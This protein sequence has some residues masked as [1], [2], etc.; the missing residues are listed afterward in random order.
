MD[1]PINLEEKEQITV[2]DQDAKLLW[3]G[4]EK[5][6]CIYITNF[7][8]IIFYDINE[9]DSQR[10]L[11][12]ITK[13]VKYLPNYEVLLELEIK[14]IVEIVREEKFDKYLLK[15]SKYFYL[16]SESAYKVLLK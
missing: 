7:R 16:L 10:E 11:L 12:R 13:A 9:V 8:F 3:N 1:F 5:K 4:R 6:V 14:D 2:I 15:N